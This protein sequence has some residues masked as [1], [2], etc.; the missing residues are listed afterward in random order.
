MLD[1][2]SERRPD[3]RVAVRFVVAVALASIATGLVAIITGPRLEGPG[4]VALAQSIAEF[5]GTVVGFALL[6]AAWGMRRGSRLAYIAA[7]VLVAL[8]AGHGIAQSRALSVPLVILS[9]VGFIVLAL[10]SP[11]FTRSSSFTSTQI[12]AIL[13]IVGVCG[14]GTVGAYTLR[15]EFTG[16]ETVLDAFYF[17]L[18]TASTVGYGDVHAAG[19]GARVFVISLI[20]LGPTAVAIAIGSVVEPELEARFP[21][22]RDQARADGGTRAVPDRVV[23]LG[24]SPVSRPALSGLVGRVPLVVVT[25]DKERA[26]GLEYHGVDVH[27]GDL[28]DETTLREVG[29]ED[30][31]V[32]LVATGSDLE[33]AHVALAAR[34]IEPDARVVAFA[35]GGG[36][37][38][39]EGVGV[40]AVIDPWDLL[41][42]T[43][44]DAVLENG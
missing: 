40:D 15:T 32:V 12:G 38:T 7:A 43:I 25:A 37:E 30:G 27:H 20:V 9:V 22:H 14:Y 1:R 2:L 41:G 3:A 8:S 5:S 23:V 16:V 44:A 31:D 6:V 26:A 36:V 29:L 17:T 28:T 35:T 10:T 42:R 39:L 13:A 34:G 24:C 18:V 19:E 33:T 11:R 4:I 21:T